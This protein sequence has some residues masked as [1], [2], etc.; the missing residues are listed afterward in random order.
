MSPASTKPPEKVG[1]PYRLWDGNGQF[2]AIVIGSGI[3]GLTTAALLAKSAGRRVLV[4]ERHYVAGGYTHIFKRPG[5]EWDVGLH[6]VGQFHHTASLLARLMETVSEGS[7]GWEPMGDV[8]DRIVIAGESYDFLTGA[9]RFRAALK[10]SFP[11][12]SRA[13]DQYFYRI[14]SCVRASR[15]FFTEKALPNPLALLAGR[16][17]RFPFLRY[18]RRTTAEVLGSLTRNRQ[19]IGVLTGQWFDFG[20]PPG[21]SSFGIHAIIA[22][23]YLEGACYPAGG[24]SR[25]AAAIV[26]VIERAGGL[27]LLNA[28]VDQ[29]VVEK[30]RAVGV[31]FADGRVVRAATVISGAGASNTFGRLLP[32]QVAEQY[33]FPEKLRQ[34]GP[35]LSHINLYVGLRQSDAEL[36][37]AKTNLWIYPTADHDRNLAAYL[38]DPAVPLPLVY[39]SF[40]SAKDPTFAE[41]YPGRSTLQLIAP[42]RYDW[43]RDWENAPWKRRGESYEQ[44]KQSLAERL[45]EK[46]YEHVPQVRGKVDHAELSTP[47]STRHFAGYSQG[48]PYGLAHTPARFDQRFLKP[49]TP[50][51][52]LFLTGQDIAVCGIGGGLVSGALTASSILGRNLLK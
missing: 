41:R 2:D 40:P 46:L 8:Y 22:Q 1:Q 10:Q 29:I 47:L 44:L 51:S 3:G 26:P 30:S 39:I 49:R 19:L 6:Y 25:I 45:L 17:L 21:Q 5:Y 14:Q 13:I 27:V 20:L 11:T 50:I 38:A 33:R 18:A 4:L 42:A 23:H 36:G 12:E 52:G 15:L 7:L 31:R 43:F 16:L 32:A 35:S 28:E 48:E 24:A 34:I 37:L 9:D